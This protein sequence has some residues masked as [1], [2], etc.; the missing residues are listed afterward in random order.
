MK[1]PDGPDS[2]D[3]TASSGGAPAHGE[4]TARPDRN[5]ARRAAKGTSQHGIETLETNVL[6]AVRGAITEFAVTRGVHPDLSDIDV[7]IEKTSENSTSD[8]V[9]NAAKA[10]QRSSE[11]RPIAVLPRLI[12]IARRSLSATGLQNRPRVALSL[13]VIAALTIAVASTLSIYDR[14]L[15]QRSSGTALAGWRAKI[16]TR[17]PPLPAPHPSRMLRNGQRLVPTKSK[18]N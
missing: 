6:G 5:G 18:A 10:D 2:P 4:A 12:S 17:L 13:A 3:A 14:S 11:S 1:R 16:V 7:N 15:L 8:D 9:G